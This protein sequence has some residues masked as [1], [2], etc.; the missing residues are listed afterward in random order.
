M[1][2]LGGL[3]VIR[4]PL[5]GRRRCG[6]PTAGL[7]A[8]LGIVALESKPVAARDF[9]ERRQIGIVR[10]PGKEGGQFTRHAIGGPQA[11]SRGAFMHWVRKRIVEFSSSGNRKRIEEFQS[12]SLCSW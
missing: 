2:V 8:A 5:I 12:H 7:V 3:G 6:C 4:V 11:D 10:P 1:P 9:A